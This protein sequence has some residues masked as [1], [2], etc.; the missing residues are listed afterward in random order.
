MTEFTPGPWKT[1]PPLKPGPNQEND[2][3]IV[4]P[5]REHVAEVFQYQ[6]P[7]NQN[8]PSIANAN[9]IVAAPEL[10]EAAEQVLQK[11]NPDVVSVNAR[12][13]LDKLRAALARAKGETP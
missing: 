10:Y 12:R 1:V 13:A 3:L 7:S 2:R 6:N 5:H 8:G 4:G 11:T 9:L